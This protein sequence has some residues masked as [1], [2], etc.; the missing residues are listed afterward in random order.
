[1]KKELIYHPDKGWV[2]VPQEKLML[3]W[4]ANPPGMAKYTPR[5]NSGDFVYVYVGEPEEIVRNHNKY[6]EDKIFLLQKEIREWTKRLITEP[7]L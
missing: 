7:M 1:M 5:K 4:R 3:T 2:K 6:Y